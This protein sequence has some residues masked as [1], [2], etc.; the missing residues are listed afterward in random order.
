MANSPS[1]LKRARQN[2][3]RTDRN[4]SVRTRVRTERKRVNEA[5]LAGDKT[6]AQ[7]AFK[8]MCSVTDKAGRANIISPNAADRY[9]SRAALKIAAM[10]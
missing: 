7:D 10:A 9:K 3:T 2:V 5:I 4:K 6:A 1:A 8:L